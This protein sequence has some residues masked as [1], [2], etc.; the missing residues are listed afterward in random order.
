MGFKSNLQ[1]NDPTVVFIS[2]PMNGKSDDEIMAERLKAI[3]YVRSIHP[4]AQFPETYINDEPDNS[5]CNMGIWYLAKS[6]E[7]LSKCD[8]IYMADGWTNARGCLIERQI[9]IAYG[10]IEILVKEGGEQE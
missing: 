3:E 2:Q 9:A 7:I 8:G 1:R 4:N 5:V 6:I 10:L